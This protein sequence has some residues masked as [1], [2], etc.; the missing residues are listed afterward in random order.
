MGMTETIEFI[1]LILETAGLIALLI[2]SGIIVAAG[3]MALF[4][5]D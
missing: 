2:I 5:E 1:G 3:I 4:K